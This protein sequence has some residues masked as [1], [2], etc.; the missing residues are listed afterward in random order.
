[1]IQVWDYLAEY[2]EEKKHIHEAIEK[3]FKS[4]RLILGESVAN[5]E[6]EFAHYCNLKYGVGVNSGT[7][8]L[9][10][11]LKTLGIGAGDEVITVPNTAIPTVSA[12]C[13]A[14]ATPRFVDVGPET[15]LINTN[16]IEKNI[17]NKTKCIMPVHLYGQCC[18]MDHIQDIVQKHNLHIIEDCAQSHGARWKNKIAG[19]MSTIGAFSFYPTKIL[20]TYG[21]GG[22]V[23][24]N[25]EEYAKKAKM[26]RMYGM[27]P[28]GEYY[29]Y[30]P[31][32]NSRLDEL[33]AEIL[34]FKLT[35][36]DQY[37]KKRRAIAARYCEGL[38]D[39]S[40]VLPK[41]QENSFHSYY[42]F[43]CKHKDRDEIIEYMKKYDIILNVSYKYPIH[44]MKSYR[45]LGYK[46]GDFPVTELIENQIF[47]LP[48]YPG[49]TVKDQDTVI[50]RLKQF[51]ESH[52]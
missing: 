39:T 42:L 35:R 33:H 5:F 47:S 24:T 38:K 11:A 31:G 19:S 23:V 30:I 14:G 46:E 3:V 52:N 29:S 6:Q 22:M 18:D 36:L 16:Q 2:E 43:V 8:A 49:L 15:F 4:G 21:D 40:I 1:M 51:L 48:M 44:L 7:D 28:N 13:A 50:E 41:T 32:Y 9:F 45:Y 10:I 26:L 17:T 20:G 37:I 25:S 12:I 34:R 27:E